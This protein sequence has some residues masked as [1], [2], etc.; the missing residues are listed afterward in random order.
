M[1]LY[2]CKAP[3]SREEAGKRRVCEAETDW[4]GR[5]S[6]SANSSARLLQL[7]P[8][9]L[10]HSTDTAGLRLPPHDTNAVPAVQPKWLPQKW[11][12][13]SVHELKWRSAAAETIHDPAPTWGLTVSPLAEE[14]PHQH[15]QASLREGPSRVRSAWQMARPATQW[16]MLQ[17][18]SHLMGERPTIGRGQPVMW[19][20]GHSVSR[21]TALQGERRAFWFYGGREQRRSQGPVSVEMYRLALQ[22]RHGS[23]ALGYPQNFRPMFATESY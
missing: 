2:D 19:Q 20:R 22:T 9:C 1:N 21:V 6:A 18:V 23:P 17:V 8:S 13:N 16:L 14:R 10:S 11:R 15:L 12:V 3:F 4:E 7:L 5:A